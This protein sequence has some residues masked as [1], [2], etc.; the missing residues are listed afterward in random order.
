[1]ILSSVKILI[2]ILF[3]SFFKNLKEKILES[4]QPHYWF[5]LNSSEKNVTEETQTNKKNP[6]NV[7]R[8]NDIHKDNKNK[9]KINDIDVTYYSMR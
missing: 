1:M 8:T 2:C 4:F 6:I 3:C 9:K 7:P 5:H